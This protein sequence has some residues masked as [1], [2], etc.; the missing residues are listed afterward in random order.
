MS[1]EYRYESRQFCT[2]RYSLP[3]GTGLKEGLVHRQIDKSWM[4]AEWNL[5]IV[6]GSTEE[7]PLI[8]PGWESVEEKGGW[9][10]HV[11]GDTFSHI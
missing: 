3:A 11:G 7:G 4:G 9:T 1:W 10:H 8:Q 2:Q 5:G 6:R